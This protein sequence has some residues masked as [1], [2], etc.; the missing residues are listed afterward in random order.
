MLTFLTYFYIEL[1][2]YI[3]WIAGSIF[4]LFIVVFYVSFK[5]IL[6]GQW[7]IIGKQ[8]LTIHSQYKQ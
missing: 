2:L 7:V 6:A 4:I 8:N 3:Y 5:L 1:I